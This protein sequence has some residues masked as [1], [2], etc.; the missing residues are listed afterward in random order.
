MMK[1]QRNGYQENVPEGN[2]TMYDKSI[3]NWY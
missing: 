3:A 2:K 1:T